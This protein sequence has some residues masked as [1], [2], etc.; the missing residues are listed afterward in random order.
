M[1]LQRSSTVEFAE[2]VKDYGAQRVLHGLNLDIGAGEFV[3]LLGPSGCGKTT[4]L[5]VLAGLE[6]ASGGAVLINGSDVSRVPTN[7][8][9]IG[10]VF[11]SYSLFPHLSALSNVMFGLSMRRVP[12]R[13]SESRAREMLELVGLGALAERYPHQLTTRPGRRGHGDMA[14]TG[15][16]P[17]GTRRARAWVTGST[18]S[19]D[20]VHF[21]AESLILG[22]I[23][24]TSEAAEVIMGRSVSRAAVSHSW[25]SRSRRMA[26]ARPSLSRM[27]APLT[28]PPRRRRRCRR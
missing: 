2:V 25:T 6:G 14:A 7:K 15:G 8:R 22:W 9:D 12:G 10:M 17:V 24:S 18:S 28:Q 21:S 4:A 26:L 11:Q 5:R 16:P 23:T 19:R 20:S 3:S 13:E 27:R 1:T